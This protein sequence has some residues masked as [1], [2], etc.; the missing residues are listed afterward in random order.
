MLGLARHPE[1]AKAFHTFNGYILFASTFRPA[2]VSSSSCGWPPCGDRPTNG[3]GRVLA[4]T[5]GSRTTRWHAS[6]RAPTHPAGRIDAAMVRAVDELVGEG[7]IADSTWTAL[8]GE[9]D[10]Q[11]LM[12]L[13]FTVGAYELLAMAFNT[14]GVELDADLRRK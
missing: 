1:L 3:S 6:P 8:A 11:Q 7:A 13:V 4:G 12:D 5:P 9:L 14:F 10:E 2:S